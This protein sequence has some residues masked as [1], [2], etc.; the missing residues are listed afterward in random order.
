MRKIEV[1]VFQ[2]YVRT[3]EFELTSKQNIVLE[4]DIKNGEVN[5]DNGEDLLS[6]LR[7]NLGVEPQVIESCGCDR[8]VQQVRFEKLYDER[9]V[10]D[11]DWI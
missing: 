1:D 2:S 10:F 11:E 4:R 5:P 9:E 8:K 3:L 6:Y 7:Y